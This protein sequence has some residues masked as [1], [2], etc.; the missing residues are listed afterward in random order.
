M[1]GNLADKKFWSQGVQNGFA[2]SSKEMLY[3]EGE[4][5]CAWHLQ[6]QRDQAEIGV[7]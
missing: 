3:I 7:L 4:I 1:N 5:P 6:E 2:P